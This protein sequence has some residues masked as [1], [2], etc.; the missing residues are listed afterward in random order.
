V[1][2]SR[3][4]SSQHRQPHEILDGELRETL[5]QMYAEDFEAFSYDP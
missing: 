2:L 3:K 5:I 4:N 1:P